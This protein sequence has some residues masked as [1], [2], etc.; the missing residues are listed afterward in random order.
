MTGYRRRVDDQTVEWLPEN[1]TCAQKAIALTDGSGIS[2][3]SELGSDSRI[4][5]S[6]SV[7]SEIREI[8]DKLSYIARYGSGVDG[9]TNLTDLKDEYRSTER[10]LSIQAT[11]GVIE[12]TGSETITVNLTDGHGTAV[13]GT[14]TVFLDVGGRRVDVSISDGSGTTDVSTEGVPGDSVIVRAVAVQELD[15]DR[16]TQPDTLSLEIV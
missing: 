14:Y 7:A 2:D 5:V 8:Y 9:L 15:T 6:D 13:P 10:I 11:D 12:A 1:E 16:I 3:T 4:E